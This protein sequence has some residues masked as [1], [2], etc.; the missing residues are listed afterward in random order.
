MVTT[1]KDHIS[2]FFCENRCM[3]RPTSAFD[4]PDSLVFAFRKSAT[5]LKYTPTLL[6]MCLDTDKTFFKL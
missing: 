5:E 6:S 3:Y 4:W 2:L 1:V